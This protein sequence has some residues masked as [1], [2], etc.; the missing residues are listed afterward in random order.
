CKEPVGFLALVAAAIA[1]LRARRGRLGAFLAIPVALYVLTLTVW[2]EVPLGYRYA[3][4]LV[5]L[6][7]VFVAT[8]LAPLPRGWPRKALLAACA[9]IAFESLAAH[10]NYLAFFNAAVGGPARGSELFLESN[11][12][13]GQDVTTLAREL[14]RRGNPPVRLALFAAE[15]AAAYGVRGERLRGCEPVT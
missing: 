4:P 1:S 5:P 2:L 10:P 11:L 3:L 14:A 15:D 9:A 6:L 13:W 8:Q 12:D 7:C